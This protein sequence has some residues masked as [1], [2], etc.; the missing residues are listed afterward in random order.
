MATVHHRPVTGGTREMIHTANMTSVVEDKRELENDQLR[1]KTVPAELAASRHELRMAL[2]KRE[3]MTKDSKHDLIAT[4][5][6]KAL[7]ELSL[8]VKTRE[9]SKMDLAIEKEEKR[10]KQLEQVLERENLKFEEFLKEN[11]KK[12][13]EARTF[14]EKE[15]RTKQ[16]KNAEI[17]RLTTEIVTIKSEMSKFEE[18]LTDYKRYKELLFKLSPPE[19]QEAHRTTTKRVKGVDSEVSFSPGG[20][21][22]SMED[23]SLPQTQSDTQEKEANDQE[24]EDILEAEDDLDLFFTDPQQLLDLVTELTQQNLSLFN[25]STKVEKTL[26]ELQQTIETTKNNI[27]KDEEPLQ[28]QISDMHQKIIKAKERGARLKQKVQILG[29]L[30]TTNQDSMLEALDHKVGE[31]YS[32]CV[33]DGATNISTLD[34]L[35]QIESHVS[36]VLQSLNSIPEDNLKTLNKIMNH[37]R[38]TRQR[39]EKLREQREKQEERMRKYDE[40]MRSEAKK[41]VEKKV[42]KKSVPV[43]QKVKV[44]RVDRRPAE[45]DTTFLYASDDTE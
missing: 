15:A 30:N 25:I 36:S 35:T 45:M 37:E 4:E 40:R 22:P 9:I 20:E 12:S 24:I 38:R 31:V 28:I 21:T 1:N 27:E 42:M 5:R 39:E 6:Q 23:S 14:F 44:C 13:V 3:N 8:T 16:M 33:D 17:K 2:M 7:L 34:K 32:C 26:K 10:V 18:T 11:E 29:S 19:W 43:A 41:K